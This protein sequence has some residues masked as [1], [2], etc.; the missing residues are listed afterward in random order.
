MAKLPW[1]KVPYVTPLLI[2]ALIWGGGSTWWYV[3]KTEQL[4]STQPA[5]SDTAA[6]AP[7]AKTTPTPSPK[8]PIQAA[9]PEPAKTAPTVPVVVTIYFL[10]DSTEQV[11][12][13]DLSQVVAYAKATPEA[14]VLVT[15][16]YANVASAS[17]VGDLSIRR[18]DEVK[19]QLVAAGIAAAKI[20]TLPK[21][22]DTSA[23]GNDPSALA[24]ARRVEV[25]I[26]KQ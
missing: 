4:C 26:S 8:A 20:T 19:A 25:T 11:S 9:T 6:T 24:K 2:T 23:D 3:C 13:A 1:Y 7:A 12:P 17:D 22:A 18:A 15:G 21:G 10:P 5:T 16:Y 14:K